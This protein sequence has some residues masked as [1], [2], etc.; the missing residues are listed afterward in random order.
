MIKP[1]V[2]VIRAAAAQQRGFASQIIDP[3]K[4][5]IRFLEDAADLDRA[6]D[7]LA[8]LERWQA[9][10]L[11]DAFENAYVEVSLLDAAR[12]ALHETN[13]NHPFLSRPMPSF[14]VWES[15]RKEIERLHAELKEPC[16]S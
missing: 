14:G 1:S 15:Q 5:K 12:Q 4:A 11:Q 16:V 8:A 6:A 2:D 9:N 13:P 10:L 3:Q 7:R